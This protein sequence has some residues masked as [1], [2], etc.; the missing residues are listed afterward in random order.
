MEDLFWPVTVAVAP[1]PSDMDGAEEMEVD[2]VAA[3]IEEIGR[4]RQTPSKRS[5][6]I[7]HK[8]KLGEG[9]TGMYTSD[10]RKEQVEAE[11]GPCT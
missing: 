6:N 2:S 7:C 4:D 3:M 5:N 1:T 9:R 11:L 10:G 8:G